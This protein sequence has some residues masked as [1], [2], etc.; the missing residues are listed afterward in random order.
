M[1]TTCS[2]KVR[3]APEESAVVM[4]SPMRPMDVGTSWPMAKRVVAGRRGE[5]V[6]CGWRP[7]QASPKMSPGVP[8]SAMAVVMPASGAE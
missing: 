1:W 7:S 2:S 4:R 8:M 6:S 3:G 5:V